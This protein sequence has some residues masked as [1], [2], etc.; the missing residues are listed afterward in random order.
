MTPLRCALAA[1]AIAIAASVTPTI[2]AE[3]ARHA[4]QPRADEIR[5]ELREAAIEGDH[6]AA[7]RAARALIELEPNNPAHHYALAASL[8]ATGDL[9]LAEHAL[10]A[11]IDLGFTRFFDLERDPRLRPLRLTETYRLAIQSRRALLD[12]AAEQAAADFQ[13]DFPGARYITRRDPRH[14]VIT[15]ADLPESELIHAQTQLDRVARFADH[16]FPQWSET[17]PEKPHAWAILILPGERHARKLFRGRANAAGLFNPNTR[18]LI[19]RDLGP[20]LRHE[21]LHA[22]HWRHMERLGQLHPIWIR[23]GL[24]AL[25]ERLDPAD[26]ASTLPNHRA[27]IVRARAESNA[28]TPWNELFA[29]DHRRFHQSYARTY[30]A[31]SRAIMRFLESQDRLA[32]WYRTY[33]ETYAQDPTGALAF[34]TVFDAPLD[35]IEQRF[36]AFAAGL[37]AIP[38]PAD[39]PPATLGLDLNPGRGAG[40]I[41]ATPGGRRGT[42]APSDS[43]D[44]LRLNDAITAI[45]GTPTPT[46]HELILALAQHKPGDRVTLSLRRGS[47]PL[48][49]TLEL[50][51]RD[52]H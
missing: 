14:R 21:L 27:N 37:P 47:I 31:E 51:A 30:Y 33:T 29:L 11:A 46:I 49:L 43:T 52:D 32:S 26:N 41:V 9:R 39:P 4:D 35:E 19:T 42:N 17:E 22:L 23:E 5:E 15:I 44:R 12:S 28:L 50:I 18:Q 45:N 20:A 3:Q 10:D 6:A 16:H 1:A 25:P 8:A 24:A 40:P 13:R 36:N 34:Q 38:T 2:I 48:T 7:A